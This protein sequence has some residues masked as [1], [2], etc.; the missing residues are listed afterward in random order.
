MAKFSDQYGFTDIA[1]MNYS[2]T[3]TDLTKAIVNKIVQATDPGE[4]RDWSSVMMNEG[5]SCDS[6]NYNITN[7][8]T[9][10]YLQVN[11]PNVDP[12][13]DFVVTAEDFTR[14]GAGESYG[15]H[16]S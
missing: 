2:D 1:F 5:I 14:P 8:A 4:E 11:R 6:V 9:L 3:V 10:M 7:H 12:Y 16:F 13:F 15:Q